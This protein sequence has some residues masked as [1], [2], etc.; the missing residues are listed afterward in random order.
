MVLLFST[1]LMLALTVRLYQRYHTLDFD[2]ICRI[3]HA[4]AHLEPGADE[5]ARKEEG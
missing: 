2:E 1:A 3:Y 4:E 5:T